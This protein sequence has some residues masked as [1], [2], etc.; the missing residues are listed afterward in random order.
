[1]QT[2]T[3]FCGSSS[4]VHPDYLSAARHL[5]QVV[6]ER[7]LR[8][9]Y[10]AGRNG[11]MGAAADGALQ[12]GGQVY[13]IIP[14]VFYASAQA[15]TG[16]TYMDVVADLHTSKQR[17]MEIADAYVVLPG[18][19]GTFAELFEILTWAQ[20]GLHH[21]PI[22]LLNVRGYFDPVHH[23]LQHVLEEKFIYPEHLN[24]YLRAASPSDLLD[25]LA[26]YH[27]PGGLERWLI[28]P[29]NDA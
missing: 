23:L 25:Q 27:P 16:L 18:G 7:G 9:A 29:E 12:A 24:L 19:Y 1:M 11:L 17:L 10:G 3:V 14:Q 4:K 2:I 22:G 6:A 28:R 13:G 21:K 15:H 5:G 20:A 8:L 26:A